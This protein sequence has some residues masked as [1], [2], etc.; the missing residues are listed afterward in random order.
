MA[1][2]IPWW[3]HTLLF[4]FGMFF[5]GCVVQVA[6][7]LSGVPDSGGLQSLASIVAGVIVWRWLLGRERRS[8]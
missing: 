7:A 1:N 5:G 3:K 4:I 2:R 8:T 6:L